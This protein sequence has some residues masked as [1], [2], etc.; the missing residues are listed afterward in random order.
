MRG[1][2]K[3]GPKIESGRCSPLSVSAPDK[4]RPVVV[5]TRDSSVGNLS[6]VTVAPIISTIRRRGFSSRI[7][8]R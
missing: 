5:L 1:R 8:Q 6:T 3:C 2:S 7:E 4:L